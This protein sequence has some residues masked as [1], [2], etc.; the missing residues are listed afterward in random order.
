MTQFPVV[1]DCIQVGGIPLTE[2]A[3]RIGRTPFYA[4]DRSP[5]T[6]RV[7][8]LRKHLPAEANWR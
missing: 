6:Q 5:I 1:D 7:G 3:R 2:L 4:Y 8:L